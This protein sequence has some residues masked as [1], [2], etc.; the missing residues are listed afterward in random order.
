[1]TL[2]TWLAHRR[3]NEALAV[4]AIVALVVVINATTR[5]MERMEDGRPAWVVEPW[6]FEITSALALLVLFPAIVAGHRR[7]VARF[8]GLRARTAAHVAGALVFSVAHVALMVLFRELAAGVA[9][10]EYDFGPLVFNFLYELRKD[11]LTYAVVIALSAAYDFILDRLRGEASFL[12]EGD[13]E[14]APYR[15]RFL[16]KMLQREYLVRVEDI[17]WIASARNYVLLHCGGREYP[18]RA[19]MAAMER[20]LDPAGFRR[21]HRTAIVNLARTRAL[22]VPS[23][24]EAAVELVDGTRVPVSA[25]HLAGLR[26]ALAAVPGP[27]RSSP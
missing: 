13:P 19:T 14:P 26:E 2:E 12:P 4:L 5:I 6:F 1:V 16:V 24:G 15:R 3:R 9:G 21:V 11:G 7:I 25:R 10:R 23:E 27:G 18:M 20:E 22:H 8:P 17:D